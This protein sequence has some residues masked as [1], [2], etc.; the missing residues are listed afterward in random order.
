M[1]AISG[2]G[3]CRGL[4]RFYFN[5]RT[6]RYD[7]VTNPEPPA[8]FINQTV[9]ASEVR[10]YCSPGFQPRVESESIK[11]PRGNECDQRLGIV[12]RGYVDFFKTNVHGVTML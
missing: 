6:R 11:N 1:N 4:C 8:R 2:R 5:D 3:L 10:R 7:V 12:S 9:I